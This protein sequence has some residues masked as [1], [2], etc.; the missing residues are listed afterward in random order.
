VKLNELNPFEI[1]K[2][3]VI[4]VQNVINAALENKVE[5]VIFAS[6]DKAVNPTS[7]MGAS[8]LLGERL[9]IAANSFTGEQKTS[10]CCVRFGNI[11][12]SSGSVIP[13]FRQ[14]LSNAEPLTITD[15]G[16]TRFLITMDSAIDL[17]LFSEETMIG[18]EIFIASMGAA[19]ILDIAKALNNGEMPNYN[20]IGIQSGEKLYEELITESEL[21]RAYN[22]ASYV[23][24]LPDLFEGS[25]VKNQKK[26]SEKYKKQLKSDYSLRSDR[27]LLSSKDVAKLVI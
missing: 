27:Q 10:F 13:I 2:T 15:V 25:A 7:S 3:N 11:I 21:R 26:F 1:V 18:G 14:Q 20:T 17:L 16:M 23:V 12:N 9:F 8:K 19:N 4:G 22:I 6:S 24:V 5:K